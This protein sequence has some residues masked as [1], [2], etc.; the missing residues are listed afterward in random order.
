MDTFVRYRM[1]V[2][3]CYNFDCLYVTKHNRLSKQPFLTHTMGCYGSNMAFLA[4]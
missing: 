4:C 3:G 1:N 2:N